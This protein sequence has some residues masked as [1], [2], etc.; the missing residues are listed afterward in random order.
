MSEV[1]LDIEDAR[2]RRLARHAVLESRERLEHD[3]LGEILV[4]LIGPCARVVADVDQAML[5]VR[6]DPRLVLIDLAVRGVDEHDRV[7]QRLVEPAQ[8]RAIRGRVTDRDDAPPRQLLVEALLHRIEQRPERFPRHLL[9]GSRRTFGR[10]EHRVDRGRRELRG[11]PVVLPRI[12]D[13]HV[14]AV[15]VDDRLGAPAIVAARD[16]YVHRAMRRLEPPVLASRDQLAERHRRRRVVRGHLELGVGLLALAV[17]T[18]Q[19]RSAV[20]RLVLTRARER[21]RGRDGQSD[22]HVHDIVGAR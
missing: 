11:E 13:M 8:E 5:V 16:P 3:G 22:S 6:V 9:V 10:D 2:A 19:A 4:Q 20:L 18:R 14:I 21:E 12:V 15:D 17:Q 7:E 1:R